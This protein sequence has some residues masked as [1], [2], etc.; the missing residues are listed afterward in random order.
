MI[1]LVW[2]LLLIVC[3]IVWF[4]DRKEPFETKKITDF[5][6]LTYPYMDEKKQIFH[7]L[8]NL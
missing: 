5:F 6:E 3:V 1:K 4:R 8:K 7:G 2:I